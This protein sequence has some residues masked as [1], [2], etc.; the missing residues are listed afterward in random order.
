VVADL[1]GEDTLWVSNRRAKVV[2]SGTDHGIDLAVLMVDGSALP[3]EFRPLPLASGPDP[4]PGTTCSLW[5]YSQLHSNSDK[6]VGRRL[7]GRL[8]TAVA[9]QSQ[10]AEQ[11][12][13]AWELAIDATSAPLVGGYSGSPVIVD[14]LGVVAV[15]SHR[16][17]DRSGLVIATSVLHPLLSGLPIS[18]VAGG[19]TAFPADE[20]WPKPP[21]EGPNPD[22]PQKDRWGGVAESGGV[23]LTAVLTTVWN[24]RFFVDL[25]VSATDGQSVGGPARFHLHPT[26]PRSVLTIRKVRANETLVLEDVMA[27]GTYTVGA[28]VCRPDGSVARVEFDLDHL[29][30]IP[31]RFR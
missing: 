19:P 17:D 23:K 9:L 14:G 5:G 16:Y 27:Y 28:E 30:G 6:Y 8:G 20:G 7:S 29:A 4:K 31:R 1:G 24:N 15:A 13:L 26:Y 21:P 18:E 11:A 2:Y 12:A 25:V 10:T 3:I 22:D